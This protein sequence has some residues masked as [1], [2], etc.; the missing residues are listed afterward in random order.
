MTTSSNV[1]DLYVEM[2]IL[3]AGQTPA[4]LTE[5]FCGL[6]WSFWANA[7]AVTQIRPLPL[8]SNTD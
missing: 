4:I 7:M 2:A 6:P 3:N 5:G 1:S 8:P